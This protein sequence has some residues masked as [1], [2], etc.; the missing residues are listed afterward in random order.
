MENL[1]RIIRFA[2]TANPELEGRTMAPAS[3]REIERLGALVEH[4]LGSLEDLLRT[5]NGDDST[6]GLLG[7]SWRMLSAA[8]ILARLEMIGGTQF[9]ISPLS[10]RVPFVESWPFEWVP[11]LDWN[12]SI[13]GVVDLASEPGSQIYGIDL[14]SGIA[15]YW[16]QSLDAFFARALEVLSSGRKLSVDELVQER[17]SRYFV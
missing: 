11:F 1:A 6:V 10:P 2:E 5:W 17:H 3:A 8:E 9:G 4:P 14:Q 7:G 13:L 16:S 12:S 15:A